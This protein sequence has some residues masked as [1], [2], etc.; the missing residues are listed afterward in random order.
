MNTLLPVIDPETALPEVEKMIYDLS[1]RFSQTYPITFEEAKSEA[2]FAFVKACYD[3]KPG[4]KTKFTTWC[5]YWIW[6]KLKD[7][8][9]KGSKD[10]LH[11]VEMKEELCG[12]APPERAVSLE[13]FD[14][15]STEAKEIISLLIE[16]P[17]D[18]LPT[19]E[20]V[21]AKQLLNRVKTYLEDRGIERTVL[22]RASEEIR[23]RLRGNAGYC[24]A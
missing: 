17:A 5:Y 19:K 23:L 7:L 8:V 14:D 16:T 9:I 15:L 3:Y 22:E 1:W 4:R 2:Y 6:C 12:E 18:L 20:P 21:Q 24:V 11:F 13:L 10:P